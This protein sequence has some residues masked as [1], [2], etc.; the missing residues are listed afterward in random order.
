MAKDVL[1]PLILLPLPLE[2]W[3]HMHALVHP[4]MHAR[5]AICP[6]SHTPD[7]AKAFLQLYT[8]E[9]AERQEST[10]RARGA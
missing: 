10:K 3:N 2:R 8:M 4:L 7:P 6:L 5:H 1:E 9:K